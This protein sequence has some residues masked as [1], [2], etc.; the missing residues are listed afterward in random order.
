VRAEDQERRVGPGAKIAISERRR[1]RRGVLFVAL[2]GTLL[3]GCS[4]PGTQSTLSLSESVSAL[5]STCATKSAS[6]QITNVS[7]AH[8]VV[9]L[10]VT[11]LSVSGAV[12][13]SAMVPPTS[14][15]AHG[16]AN[17]SATPTQP[18]DNPLS[19]TATVTSV[20]AG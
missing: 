19:C 18:A 7:G 4:L 20:H 8:V 13:R 12:L 16:S 14:V 17:W 11:W 3:F 6:G 10:K 15:A 9:T 2:A 1:F 5:A